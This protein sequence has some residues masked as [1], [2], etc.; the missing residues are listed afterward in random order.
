MTPEE[1]AAKIEQ[2]MAW[3]HPWSTIE[4]LRK[5]VETAERLLQAHDCDTQGWEEIQAAAELG[6]E[7]LTALEGETRRRPE[8]GRHG[9]GIDLAKRGTAEG[10]GAGRGPGEQ[11]DR[12][13]ERAMTQGKDSVPHD[14]GAG[15]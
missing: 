14:G 10:P 12:R 4:V 1:R 15:P 11:I 7:R 8:Q 13:E 3:D 2:F 6:R 9:E 5:L